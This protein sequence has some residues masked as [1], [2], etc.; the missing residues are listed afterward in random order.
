[1]IDRE[2]KYLVASIP[3]P[4]AE[5]ECSKHGMSSAFANGNGDVFCCRCWEDG[6]KEY[7][8][9]KRNEG[10]FIGVDYGYGDRQVVVIVNRY[11][12]VL[13]S[14]PIAE[15][16][17]QKMRHWLTMGARVLGPIVRPTT[18]QAGSEGQK[19]DG[20]AHQDKTKITKE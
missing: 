15:I 18:A 5:I 4:S 10:A 12:D 8:S 7:E 3:P 11:G 13:D 1:M 14:C 20:P 6:L 9:R 2:P 19:L 16:S 17:P